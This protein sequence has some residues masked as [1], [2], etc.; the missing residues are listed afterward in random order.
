[1]NSKIFIIFVFYGT[2]LLQCDRLG[3]E[4]HDG[5]LGPFDHP[6]TGLFALP[7]LNRVTSSETAG[8]PLRT[9][10]WLSQGRSTPRLVWLHV[11]QVAHNAHYGQLVKRAV[12]LNVQNIIHPSSRTCFKIPSDRPPILFFE[13][14]RI[15]G[16]AET[17]SA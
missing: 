1:M 5:H 9:R 6:D 3:N 16:D 8:P 7:D 14:V 11:S 10:K 15:T 17:S 4:C 2:N 12:M 13:S